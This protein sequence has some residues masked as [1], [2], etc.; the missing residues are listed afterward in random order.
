[1]LLGVAALLPAAAA[2]GSHKVSDLQV[3][4]GPSPFREGDGQVVTRAG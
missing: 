3:L 4:S 2:V 1:M